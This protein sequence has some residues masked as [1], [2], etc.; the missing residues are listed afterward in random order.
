MTTGERTTKKD[1]YEVITSKILDLL[2]ASTVP[3]KATWSPIPGIH[4]MSANT[5]KAY[6]GIKKTRSS[7]WL[8]PKP[9]AKPWGECS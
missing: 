7:P 4:P 2:E 3:W 6:R 8:R 9:T 1:A 5:V